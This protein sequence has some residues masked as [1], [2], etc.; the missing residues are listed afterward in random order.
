M[1]LINETKSWGDLENHYHQ[2]KLIHMRDLFASDDHRGSS[3]C[4][5]AGDLFLDYSKNIITAETMRLLVALAETAGVKKEIARMFAGDKI[6]VTE[7]RAVLHVA[8]RNMSGSFFYVDEKD[9]MA[10]VNH[11]LEKMRIF[12]TAIRKGEWKGYTGK[13]IKNIINIGIGGSDLGPVMAYEALKYYSQRNLNVRFVSNI[14][15]SHFQEVVRDCDPAQTLFIIASKTFTTEETMTNAESARK[16][17]LAKLGDVAAVERHFVALSTNADAVSKFGIDHHQ[18]Y[19]FWD[20]VGGRYSLCSAIGLSLMIAIGPENFD[21][22]R[23]GFYKMDMHFKDAPLSENM[24]VL[25][26]LLGI[27]YN[28][29]F[30]AHTY[31]LLPYSQYLNRFPAYFQQGDMESSGKSVTK[32]GVFASYETGPVIWGEPGT[33]GQHAFYQL[34]HQGTQLVSC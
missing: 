12:A 11:E 13:K 1:T 32:D 14:D 33:N 23:H 5:T 30:H 6:N 2:M 4:L 17:L 26:A 24:P 3:F 8:L 25:L 10:D 28:N 29:F 18:M 16:W 27:W 34:L 7:K 20:W 15:G 19:Q 9:I 22:L 31:A 21:A